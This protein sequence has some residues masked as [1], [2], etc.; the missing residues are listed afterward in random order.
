M[1]TWSPLEAQR[2]QEKASVLT[3]MWKFCEGTSRQGA[4]SS[5]SFSHCHSLPSVRDVNSFDNT[6][7]IHTL[8]SVSHSSKEKDMG[9]SD[10]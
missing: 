8:M 1:P 7:V 9:T 3:N 2:N 4:R 5:L 10:L 6:P